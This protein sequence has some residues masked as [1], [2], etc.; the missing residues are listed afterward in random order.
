[1]ITTPALAASLVDFLDDATVSPR[2]RGD[3]AG[4]NRTQQ[5]QDAKYEVRDLPGR[6]KGLVAA[7]R[8]SQL[9][10][11]LVGFP[12]LIVRIDFVNQDRY[13][14]RQ[15]RRLMRASVDRLPAAQ[16]EAVMALARSTGGE[17]IL[18]ILRTNGFGV[19][20]G[21]VQHLALFPD[22]SVSKYLVTPV[23]TTRSEFLSL[24]RA[25]LNRRE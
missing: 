2:F 18:D 13:T 20:I 1:M 15:K 6:G 14:E 24:T 4:P 8:F 7:Q 23:C 10:T 22:G 19:E 3:L 16:K 9:E 21:G 17:P 25:P 5:Y 12:V 11:I